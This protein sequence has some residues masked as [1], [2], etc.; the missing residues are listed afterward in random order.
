MTG[1]RSTGVVVSLALLASLVCHVAIQRHFERRTRT[2][3][4]VAIDS[5]SEIDLSTTTAPRICPPV[6]MPE[7]RA[8]RLPRFLADQQPGNFKSHILPALQIQEGDAGEQP[9]RA[10][11]SPTTVPVPGDAG[12]AEE[13][14]DEEFVSRNV[15][16][17]AVRDVIEHELAHAPREERD[18]WFDELKT[19]P[20]GV[21]RDLLQVR[22]QLRALPR[23]LGG[24]PEKLASTDPA[25]APHTHEIIAEPVSQKIRF[26]LPDHHSAAAA[27]E[28]AVSQLRHNLVNAATP[29]FKRLRVTLV[30]AYATRWQDPGLTDGLAQGTSPGSNIHGEGCRMAPLLLDMKQGS[31]KKTGRQLDLAIDGDGFFVVKRGESELVTRCGALGLDRDRQLCLAFANEAA[32][33][34]PSIRIPEDSREIQ[35]SADGIVTVLKTND[36]ALVVIGQLQLARFASPARLQPAG[37]T[38]FVASEA[39]GPAQTGCPLAN[40]RGELQQ[41]CL[42]QSNVD[43]EA[44]LDEIEEFMAILKAVPF[45][46]SRPVTA[47]G[48]QQTP[49]R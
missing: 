23:L 41:G 16:T 46:N 45:L 7:L 13:P 25:V 1:V 32:V 9:L 20:A 8:L 37:Q 33:L 6:D 5:M 47:S 48:A 38:L 24:I 39:S 17:S 2:I 49:H 27:L 12:L 35:I 22:K 36:A 15:D 40:G 4:P 31:L 30:D 34:Q 14:A 42:E 3:A 28:A 11:N 21:V 26:N 44:E 19:L 29:G 18:I 10:D 43:F